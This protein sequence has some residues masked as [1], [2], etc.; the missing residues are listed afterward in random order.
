MH[1]QAALWMILRI[2]QAVDISVTES[3][4]CS[5]ASFGSLISERSVGPNGSRPPSFFFFPAPSG[6]EPLWKCFFVLCHLHH[7]HSCACL[8]SMYLMFICSPQAT[9][10]ESYIWY[11]YIY[12]IKTWHAKMMMSLRLVKRHRIW[13]WFLSLSSRLRIENGSNCSR[14]Q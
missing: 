6:L 2:P 3:P 7:L 13:I 11:V 5:S 10:H 8:E 12:M 1:A 9:P 4:V 14:H